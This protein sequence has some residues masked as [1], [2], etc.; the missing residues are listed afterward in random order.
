MPGLNGFG[1]LDEL[2]SD[3]VLRD[4]PVLVI[5]ASDDLA[6]VADSLQ[7]GA[8]DYLVKP[9]DPMLLQ[10]RLSSTLERKRLRDR[11][12]LKNMENERLASA[13]QRS[14]EDLQ[15][16]AYAASHDLQAPVRTMTTY[17]Q[18]LRRRLKARLAPEEGEMFDFAEG[19]AKR[20][21]VLIHDLLQYS[22][23]STQEAR[24]ES[25]DCDTLL[26]SL[27][28]DMDAVIQDAGAVVTWEPLPVITY[29]PTRLRQ[30][31]QNLIG[32]AI[33]YRGKDAP[34]IQVLSALEDD[35]WRFCVRDNGQGIAPEHA[36]RIFDMFHRLHGDNIPGSGIGLAICKRIVER[37]GGK[38]WVHS[39]VDQGST[40]CFT[41]PFRASSEIA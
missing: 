37:A 10:A 5:S 16:F 31:L 41:I 23:A 35:H 34:E 18:L 39:E 11:E 14:N 17:L 30:V 6:A 1:V 25:V 9:F 27:L 28:L 19:A 13:L 3:S 4:L 29:D 22:Q 12:R 7:R 36:P 33:K 32:N 21:H 38:I 40:F 26:S 24:A 2:Q 8:E 20:M 15:R